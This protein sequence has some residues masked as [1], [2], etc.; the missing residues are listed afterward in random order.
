[1]SVLGRVLVA[2][3]LGAGAP[4][5]REP[6]GPLAPEPAETEAAQPAPVEAAP[7]P[8][9]A[10]PAET[11]SVPVE[12]R[13][14]APAEAVP[15]DVGSAAEP[16]PAASPAAGEPVGSRPSPE[17]PVGRR[18]DTRQ[19]TNFFGA[20]ATARWG[21][22]EW[23]DLGGARVAGGGGALLGRLAGYASATPR[24]GRGRRLLTPEL[25][26]LVELGGSGLRDPGEWWK[27]AGGVD[28][29][30]SG[31]LRIGVGRA[32]STRVSP[33]GKL[34]VDQRFLVMGRPPAEGNHLVAALRG[35]AGLLAHARREVVVV[36]AG[37]ALDGVVG[38]QRLGT[39]VLVAQ[40]M[41][42]AE[43][44]IYAH[45]LRHLALAWT[46]DVRTTIAGERTGGRRL[47][48]RAT[49]DLMVGRSSASRVGYASLL[50]AYG[51][52]RLSGVSM[53]G[54]AGWQRTGHTILLGA[55]IALSR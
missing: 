5:G 11:A 15:A 20:G 51:L 7:A 25:F 9:E 39:R 49:F 22:R 2:L 32:L 36:L 33:Y 18:R 53:E 44:A 41:A 46:L 48:G 24:F 23:T 10:A 45:P 28:G 30:A 21:R 12:A 37:A 55:G 26:A 16:L 43:L 19:F 38:A 17:A 8:A 47:E 42:G 54:G 52:S 34:Q 29:G 4:G 3:S 35:S 6:S 14:G 40:V 50:L 31:V 13:E 1:M 27:R